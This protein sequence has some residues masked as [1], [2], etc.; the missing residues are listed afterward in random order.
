VGCLLDTVQ[1]TMSFSKNG[2]VYGPAFQVPQ[3]LQGQVSSICLGGC[4]G[5]CNLHAHMAPTTTVASPT[6]R[7]HPR[8]CART[9]KSRYCAANKT[10][11]G[12]VVMWCA[13]SGADAVGRAEQ[14][15]WPNGPLSFGCV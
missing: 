15:L 9:R 8:L 13:D 7:D 2:N 4:Y 3:H 5:A 1:G 10:A 6:K 14:R 12:W 11:Q